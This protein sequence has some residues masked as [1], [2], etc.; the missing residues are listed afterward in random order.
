M[1][2]SLMQMNVQS[3]NVISDLSGVTGQAIIRA[4]RALAAVSTALTSPTMRREGLRAVSVAGT[5]TVTRTA[6]RVGPR[7]VTLLLAN[8]LVTSFS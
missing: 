1:Q 4:I 8:R 5:I 6:R 2:K 7:V 3:A